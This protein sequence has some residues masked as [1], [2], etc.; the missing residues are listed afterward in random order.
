MKNRLL[1]A[2]VIAALGLLISL[3]PVC[4]FPACAKMI[5]TAA[6]GTVP[7][8][9]F[10][11]GRAEIGIG[12]LI[13]GGGVLIACFKSPLVRIGISMMTALTGI[14]GILIPALL[15]GGCE[16]ATMTCRMTTFPALILLNVLTVIAGLVNAIYL[17]QQNRSV[18]GV[19]EWT[20]S[21]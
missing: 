16:M 11:S 15:I 4:I 13:L 10:W 17:W 9:C 6:G 18:T 2:S 8:K 21:H 19:K 5:E 7:M 14:L 1:S 3:V 20:S 12:L